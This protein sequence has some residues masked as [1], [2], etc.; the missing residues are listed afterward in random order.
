MKTIIYLF[1]LILLSS[2]PKD[3]AP[4]SIAKTSSKTGNAIDN[5]AKK[6]P[7]I[8]ITFEGGPF[9]GTHIFTPA[10]GDYLSQINVGY[11]DGVST[12]NS[13]KIVSENGIQIHTI[14]RG[15]MGDASVGNQT[16]KK[17]TEGCGHLNFID[18]KNNQAYKRIDGN[19]TGCSTTQITQVT[20]WKKGTV[21]FRR[22][23]A[24]KFSDNI[25]FEI[26]NDDGSQEIIQTKVRVEFLANQSKL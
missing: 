7:Y 22:K 9:Q 10:K 13:S 2:C 19:F 3:K 24:G 8:K 14:S 21:K 17:Y 11:H 25:S 23:V 5:I 6:K 12:L 16:T 4:E 18:L 15:F 20:P 26:T 1:S